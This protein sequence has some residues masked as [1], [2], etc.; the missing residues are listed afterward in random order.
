MWGE[1]TRCPFYS[2]GQDH[3]SPLKMLGKFTSFNE[4]SQIVDS[5]CIHRWRCL[6]IKPRFNDL[7]RFFC[8]KCLDTSSY[9]MDLIGVFILSKQR[10]MLN[11][12]KVIWNW[13]SFFF[14]CLRWIWQKRTLNS[15]EWKRLFSSISLGTVEGHRNHIYYVNCLLTI[16]KMMLLHI[17]I[18]G[19]I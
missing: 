5:I 11:W 15:L 10:C 1:T 19:L 6:I 12:P 18:S 14:P 8:S 2:R 9:C 4:I 13:K 17:A 3:T 16:V 7:T